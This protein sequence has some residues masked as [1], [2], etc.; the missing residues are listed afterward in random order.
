MYICPHVTAATAGNLGVR[1]VLMM[2]LFCNY[3]YFVHIL[4]KFAAKE[5]G[6]SL[7]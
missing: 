3:C 6:W 2:L 5:N 1:L 4:A 7:N